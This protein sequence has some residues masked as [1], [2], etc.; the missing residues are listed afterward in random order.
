MDLIFINRGNYGIGIENQRSV[1][2]LLLDE[3]GDV[4]LFELP[5]DGTVLFVLLV[6]HLRVLEVVDQAV[7][8]LQSGI[9]QVTYLR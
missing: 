7:Q 5:D 8:A 1:Q 3:V 4:D 6:Q 2:L 9:G